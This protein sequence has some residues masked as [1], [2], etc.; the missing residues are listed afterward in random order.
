MAETYGENYM[1]LFN[2]HIYNK[3]LLLWCFVLFNFAIYC[4]TPSLSGCQM[5]PIVGPYVPA[6]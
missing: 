4:C 2:G 5:V 3:V 1:N 6:F